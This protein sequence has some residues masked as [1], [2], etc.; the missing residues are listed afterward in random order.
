MGGVLK[1]TNNY[2]RGQADGMTKRISCRYFC[3]SFLLQFYEPTMLH[4]I[5]V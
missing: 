1:K 3:F 5:F 4:L 2:L